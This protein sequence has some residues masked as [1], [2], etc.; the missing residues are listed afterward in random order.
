MIFTK[1][2]WKV[3]FVLFFI[4]LLILPI[5]PMIFE[6]PWSEDSYKQLI[7][8]TG[9]VSARLLIITLIITPLKMMFPKNRFWKFN[10]ERYL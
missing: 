7:H 10:D 5:L 2:N 6:Y 4:G 1:D 3:V 8:V 9:E